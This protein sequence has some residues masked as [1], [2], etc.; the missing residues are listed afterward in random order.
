MEHAVVRTEGLSYSYPDGSGV[1]DIT[2]RLSAGSVYGFIGRNGAGKTTTI[3][4]LLGLLRPQKGEVY[5]NE[6][7]MSRQPI[8]L[9]QKVGY[10]AQHQH[11]YP[12]M[13]IDRLGEFVG[14]FYPTWD[15]AEFV[16]LV[17]I[18]DVPTKKKAGSLSG[19]TATRLALC[20]ALAHRPSVLIL[21]EPTAGLDPLARRELMTLLREQ[22]RQLGSAV[23]LSSHIIEDIDDA[24]D[25]IGV[26]DRGRL[27]LEDSMSSVRTKM[28]GNDLTSYL[29]SVV[30][31]T[32][33]RA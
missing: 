1:H 10:V 29:A 30:S 15:S 32:G 7:A 20:L 19:G 24:A 27:L 22:T 18:F 13:Q 14:R 6:R 5:L 9:R 23:L 2:L 11:F 12:W 28:Q 4:L 8:E 33:Q 26:I 31:D 16:R 25:C 21:D 17:G 3:K